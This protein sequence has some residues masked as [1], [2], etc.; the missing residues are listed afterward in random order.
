ML[1]R[2]W[3]KEEERREGNNEIR[4]SVFVYIKKVVA[5]GHGHGHLGGRGVVRNGL[6]IEKEVAST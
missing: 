3:G 4:S 1:A 5:A 6:G 2:S